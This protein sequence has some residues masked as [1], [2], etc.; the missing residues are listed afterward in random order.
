[1]SIFVSTFFFIFDRKA[2]KYDRITVKYDAAKESNKKEKSRTLNRCGIFALV[3]VVGLEP[4]QKTSKKMQYQD[5]FFAVSNFVSVCS[6][7]RAFWITFSVDLDSTALTFSRRSRNSS[8][9]TL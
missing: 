4:T 8:T 9:Y 2:V 5:Y 3:P 1:M 7:K 6:E